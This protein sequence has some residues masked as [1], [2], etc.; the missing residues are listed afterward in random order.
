[1]IWGVRTGKVDLSKSTIF[2]T[3]EIRWLWISMSFVKEVV[4]GKQKDG[5]GFFV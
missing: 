1:V 3:E 2:Y 5:S 4:T